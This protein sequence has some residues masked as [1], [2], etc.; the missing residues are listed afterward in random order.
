MAAELT[1]P[2]TLPVGWGGATHW[3]SPP[4]GAGG[5]VLWFTDGVTEQKLEDGR[6][7]GD[8][9]LVDLLQRAGA[10]A[11]SVPETV[12]RLSHSLMTARGGRT[13][14]DATLLLVE[15]SGPTGDAELQHGLLD[16]NPVALLRRAHQA[17]PEPS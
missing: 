2:T 9:R 6:R 8:D 7:F 15:W 5:R 14:D 1:G 17:R 13:S 16:E 10:E 12:R 4:S 3:S 11:A